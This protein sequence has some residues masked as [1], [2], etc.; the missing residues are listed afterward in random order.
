MCSP[1]APWL[2]RAH[3]D[4][5]VLR[6]FSKFGGAGLD[7]DGRPAWYDAPVAGRPPLNAK[8]WQL[9][10]RPSPTNPIRQRASETGR[11]RRPWPLAWCVCATESDG[12]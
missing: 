2:A 8:L 6:A 3:R 1:G 10:N 5:V 9:Q 4:T 11:R 12:A 7:A